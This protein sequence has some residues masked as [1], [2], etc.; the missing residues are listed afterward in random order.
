MKRYLTILFL[1]FSGLLFAQD[2]TR[3]AQDDVTIL[4][5]NEAE[6][7]LNI[8]SSGFGI[9]FRRAWHQTGYKKKLLD[10]DF[11]SVRHPKQY[12]QPNPYYP[13]SRPFFYG[14]LNFVYLLRTGVGRQHILFS[15][16]ERSGVEVRSNYCAGLDLGITK[17]VYLEI[18]VDD[19]YDSLAKVIDTRR[20]DPN[21]P[22]QQAV[23]NIYGPGPYFNGLG[24][25]S[26][27][28]GI[29]GKLA[30]SFEYAGWQ[31]KVTALEA[32]VV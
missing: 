8:H 11:V 20:Y 27:Y 4:Y 18:L 24:K 29:Y 2:S 1:F 31:Q 26:I 3:V 25:M 5:R 15:K 12:K 16:A 32:G 21:D 9:T 19:P 22:Q 10:I 6:G 23:E 17:P 30:L 13:D 14:K 28:P 7:G